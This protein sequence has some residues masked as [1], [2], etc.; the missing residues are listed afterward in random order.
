MEIFWPKR[1]WNSDSSH[2]FTTRGQFGKNLKKNSKNAKKFGRSGTRTSPMLVRVR[3]APT[4]PR[5]LVFIIGLQLI[6]IVDVKFLKKITK[7]RIICDTFLELLANGNNIPQKISKKN[8]PKGF[9]NILFEI[10]SIWKIWDKL[11]LL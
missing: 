10:F 7:F 9:R 4:T 6:Y 5:R 3:C 11:S 8:N 1:M 2:F